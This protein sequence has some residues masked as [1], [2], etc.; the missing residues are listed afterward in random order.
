[1]SVW[2][3]S[4]TLAG[5]RCTI[6]TTCVRW[7]NG[8]KRES[9]RRLVETLL[10]SGQIKVSDLGLLRTRSEEEAQG[11]VNQAMA[12][13]KHADEYEVKVVVASLYLTH[14]SVGRK[15]PMDGWWW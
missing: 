12:G 3:R 6:L 2:Q 4:S 10:A 15:S 1:M 14:G 5:C 9:T 7:S 8:W 11:V 13:W